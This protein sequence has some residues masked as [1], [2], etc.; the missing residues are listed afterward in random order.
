MDFSLLKTIEKIIAK[1]LQINRMD[2]YLIRSTDFTKVS[3]RLIAL[4]AR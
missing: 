2:F 1:I 4:Y 3:S